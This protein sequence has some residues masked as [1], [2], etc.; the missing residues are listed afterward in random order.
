MID[1]N[2]EVQVGPGRRLPC[3]FN[4]CRFGG[5][6]VVLPAEIFRGSEIAP[7]YRN[8]SFGEAYVSPCGSIF[9]HLACYCDYVAD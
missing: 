2:N 1:N 6:V 4:C 3:E 8:R 7:E 9:C 5:G